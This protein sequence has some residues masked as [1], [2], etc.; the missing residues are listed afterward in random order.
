ML[1]CPLFDKAFH[2][3]EHQTRHIRTHT[4]EKP[5]V[6]PGCTRKFARSD[7]LLRHSK[8]HNPNSRR[9]NKTHQAVQ[10][11]TQ[12]GG[13]QGGLF[14]AIMMPPQNKNMSRSAPASAIATAATAGGTTSLPS[15]L[16]PC[17]ARIPVTKTI[18]SHIEMLSVRDLTH[19]TPLLRLHQPLTTRCHQQPDHTPLATQMHSPRLRPCGGGYD[20]PAIRNLSLQQISALSPM[21]PQH[22]DGQYHTPT[23]KP[24]PLLGLDH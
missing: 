12:D 20:L 15:P 23:T 21:G 11:V 13:V 7:E 17:R 1:A 3:L 5:Y 19:Q 4:G 24:H 14:K 18:T 6:R 9:R 10:H 8:I 22:V 2:R 16:R